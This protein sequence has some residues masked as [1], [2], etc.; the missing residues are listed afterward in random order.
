M[1]RILLPVKQY[2]MLN[3]NSLDLMFKRWATF[4]SLS[5]ITL[6]IW[7]MYSQIW[8]YQITPL[9]FHHDFLPYTRVV[10][11]VPF[12]QLF[13]PANIPIVIKKV[14]DVGPPFS[15]IMFDEKMQ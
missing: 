13:S 6:L 2:Q 4:L 5:Y 15:T 8:F 9:K 10:Y 1:S 12:C 3:K 14:G 11:E 7:I